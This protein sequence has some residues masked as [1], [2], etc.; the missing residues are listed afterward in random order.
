M[1]FSHITSRCFINAP[2]DQLQQ[3]LL[4]FFLSHRLQ[5]EIGLEGDSLYSCNLRSFTDVAAAL[6]AAGLACT[7]HAPFFDL[8][9][10]ALDRHIRRATR[11]KLRLAFGLIE[12]FRPV[13]MVCHLNFEDNKHLV[14]ENEWARYALETWQELLPLAARHNTV[15]TLENTYET[16]PQQHERILRELDSPQVRFCLDVGHVMAFARNRWQDWLPALEPW[17]GQL[18]LHDNTGERDSHL[19]IGQGSFDFAGLF[20]YLRQRNLKP[21]ITLEPHSEAGLWQ[22]LESLERLG[23]FAEPETVNK[24]TP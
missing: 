10:G 6:Q 13:S 11:E 22:S 5:P 2:F 4:D 9:P 16:G 7:L 18:H 23:L 15:I 14:K 20:A 19:G 21:V 8:A 17:L 1:D 12:I 3:G 24:E